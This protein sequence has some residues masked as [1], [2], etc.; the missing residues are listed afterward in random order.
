VSVSLFV[1]V[2]PFQFVYK[3]SHFCI[4]LSGSISVFFCYGDMRV[5]VLGVG[6]HFHFVKPVQVIFWSFSC[7]LELLI[8]YAE[9]KITF[10]M[11]KNCFAV[12]SFWFMDDGSTLFESYASVSLPAS[13]CSKK[14]K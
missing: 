14:V 1:T 11:Y 13:V 3:P 9:T 10:G 2:K 6:L 8:D 4:K 5:P 7:Y 12:R